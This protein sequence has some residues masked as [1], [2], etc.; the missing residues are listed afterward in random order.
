MAQPC[1]VHRCRFLEWVPSSIRALA[2]SPS[3]ALLAV[4]RDSGDIEIWNV[5]NGWHMERRIAGASEAIRGLVWLQTQGGERLFSAGLSGTVI[6]WDLCKLCEKARTDSFGGPVWSLVASP[7]GESL[8]AGCEDGIRVFDIS[9]GELQYKRSFQRAG[10][11]RILCLAW[12]PDGKD[13]FSGG[14]D[15]SIRRWKADTGRNVSRIT[16]ESF[17]RSKTN[18]WSILVLKDWTIVTGD[19]LGKTQFWDGKTGTLIKGFRNHKADVLALATNQ[20]EDMVFS[21]G[22]DNKMAQFQYVVHERQESAAGP[23]QKD[24][25]YTSSRRNHTHDVLCMAVSPPSSSP[26]PFLS[27]TKKHFH[28]QRHYRRPEATPEY[29]QFIV[30][31]GIDTQLCL[32]S[33]HDFIDSVP[34]KQPPF[35]HHPPFSLSSSKSLL[36]CQYQHS[37]QLWNFSPAAAESSEEIAF[38]PEGT[39]LTATGAPKLVAEL[40]MKGSNLACSA[41]S[42][43]GAWIACADATQTKLFKLAVI[44]NEFTAKESLSIRKHPLPYDVLPGHRLL[45]TP[46][47]SK[48]IIA[49]NESSIQIVDLVAPD[50]PRIIKTFTQHQAQSF[51]TVPI[52]TEGEQPEA[53]TE[54]NQSGVFKTAPICTLAVSLDGQWLASGDLNNHIYVYN[55]DTLQCHTML[56]IFES[57]HTTFAFH[58]RGSTLVVVCASNQFYLYDVEEKRLSD[59]SREYGNKLPAQFMALRDKLIGIAFNPSRPSTMCLYS[60]AFF[61]HI[62]LELP[63]PNEEDLTLRST[64]AVARRQEEQSRTGGK[65]PKAKKKKAKEQSENVGSQNFKLVS[66]F[67]P[68]L[69]LDFLQGDTM[70]LVERPWLSIISHFPDP[71]HRNRYGT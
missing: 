54:P 34:R 7:T 46:D 40:K 38:V 52:G 30:S 1:Q 56:P 10:K 42:P 17:G 70:L 37:L 58:Q 21:S 3:G 20:Q 31:G 35:S 6:E 51:D 11:G 63:L 14:S 33:V 26:F 71:L 55:L 65:P 41:L 29:Y 60:T 62:D 50:E 57:Q 66:K 22:I 16:V 28:Q 53:K 12:H 24:W 48:L 9:D 49:T 59:W 25:I 61:V 2:F 5:Q 44:K 43:D 19:S 69:F 39:R 47:S 32:A 27:S 68:L 36:L 64:L 8:A 23:E 15:A 45:F 67:K 18:V 4:G 13:L